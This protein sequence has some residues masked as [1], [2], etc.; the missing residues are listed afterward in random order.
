[1]LFRNV[2]HHRVPRKASVQRE[3]ALVKVN[4]TGDDRV[5]AMAIGDKFQAQIVDSTTESF[6]FE[7]VGSSD[8]VDR[9][10]AEIM[11]LGL[12]DVSRTGIVA[13]ARGAEE[14]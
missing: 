10:I 2:G 11:P 3:L 14:M 1:M 4:G 7:I 8:T 5:E 6:V 13:I 9:F 12:V